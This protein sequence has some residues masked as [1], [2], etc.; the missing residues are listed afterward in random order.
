LKFTDAFSEPAGTR[1][2]YAGSKLHAR[3]GDSLVN[4]CRQGGAAIWHRCRRDLR[5]RR[6]AAA[7]S[8]ARDLWLE[9][10]AKCSDRGATPRR[11]CARRHRSGKP[12]RSLT[13]ATSHQARSENPVCWFP[14]H[15]VAEPLEHGT[16]KRSRRCRLESTASG[17]T[18]PNGYERVSSLCRYGSS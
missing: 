6:V 4:D 17:R 14:K 1:R 16:V 18:S 9:Q 8:A 10:R 2:G 13:C 5:F 3:S 15:A 11:F 12:R 7:F